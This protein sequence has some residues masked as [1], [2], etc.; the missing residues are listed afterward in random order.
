M[1]YHRPPVCYITILHFVS[2]GIHHVHYCLSILNGFT[3]LYDVIARKQPIWRYLKNNV[4]VISLLK[5]IAVFAH[6]IV[7]AADDDDSSNN[8]INIEDAKI[9]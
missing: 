3:Q 1:L 4:I 7:V 5:T 8:N 9:N 2:S 6:G